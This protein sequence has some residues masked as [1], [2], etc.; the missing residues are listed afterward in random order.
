MVCSV[1]NIHA[2]E[3]KTLAE[4]IHPVGFYNTKAKN[5][6]KVK[7]MHHSCLQSLNKSG[8]GDAPRELGWRGACE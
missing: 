6:K 1:E 5:I 4:L 8:G 3:E 2:M 7:V